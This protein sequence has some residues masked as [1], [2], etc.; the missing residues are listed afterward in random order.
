[1]KRLLSI[2]LTVLVMNELL[3]PL[4]YAFSMDENIVEDVVVESVTEEVSSEE[5]NESE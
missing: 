5:I 2:T 4:S 1:M 3:T